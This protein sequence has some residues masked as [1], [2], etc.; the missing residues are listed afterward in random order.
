MADSSCYAEYIA[1][2]EASREAIFLQMLMDR[3]H[4]LKVEPSPVF[5]DNDAAIKLAEDQVWHSKC[6]HIHVKYH[7]TRDQ[8]LAKEL[9]VKHI[10]TNDNVVDIFTKALGYPDFLRHRSKLGLMMPEEDVTATCAE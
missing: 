5:C 4:F 6:K 10:C 7:Y 1:L 2:S 9:T 3:I 8:I